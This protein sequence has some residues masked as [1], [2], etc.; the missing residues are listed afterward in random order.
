MAFAVR[1]GSFNFENFFT[2]ASLLNKD[3]EEARPFLDALAALQEALAAPAY[4]K[5]KILDLY[6]KVAPY[7]DVR[8]N[9]GKLFGKKQG[10]TVVKAKGAD[11]WAGSL[12]LKRDPIGADGQDNTVRVVSAVD[13]DVLCAVEMEDR[14]TLQKAGSHA[15]IPKA[16][17]Y[18]HAM[19]IEGNDPRGIDVGLLSRHP[20]TDIRSHVDDRD[21]VGRVFSRDCLE[22]RV[23]L[24]GG[25]TLRF[26]LN[27]LKSQGYGPPA[28][29]DAKR[30]RQSERVAAILASYDLDKDYVV[31]AG[32][33]NADPDAANAA[34]IAPLVTHPKLVDVL[35]AKLGAGADWTYFYGG[36]KQRLDYLL[37][38]KALAARLVS[39]GIER[40]G[41]WNLEKITAGAQKP[42]DQVGGPTTAA[43]DHAAVHAEFDLP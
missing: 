17:R 33:L 36:K 1:I 20:I 19:L 18:R 41:I 16:K 27:H 42:F 29:N 34:S 21:G 12:E 9:K 37:C 23:D 31:V 3:N 13:A 4:D 15:L 30:L 14:D 2:R 6:A 5:P 22:A 7:V 24:P 39:A 28:S 43:S 26:L 11:D 8:E 10:K 25:R 32:D 40:R 38:S 35:R